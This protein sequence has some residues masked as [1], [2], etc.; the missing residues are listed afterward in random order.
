MRFGR[1]GGEQF[2]PFSQPAP[3][4]AAM[5]QEPGGELPA[6]R[7]PRGMP[8]RDAAGPRRV[9]TERFRSFL[10]P[11]TTILQLRRNMA[12]ATGK[13]GW[14]NLQEAVRKGGAFMPGAGLKQ[15]V[16][17]HRKE[18][19]ILNP[20]SRVAA[21]SSCPSN[22]TMTLWLEAACHTG[23]LCGYRRGRGRYPLRE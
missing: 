9:Q 13:K 23:P 3:A 12:G 10:I 7:P 2:D 11:R 18:K 6:S 1:H 5:P 4:R 22:A 17:A 14:G 15:L 8:V 16:K 21:S 20:P 19:Y